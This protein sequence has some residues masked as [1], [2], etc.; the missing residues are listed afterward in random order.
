[1]FSSYDDLEELHDS[2]NDFPD[3]ECLN[4]KPNKTNNSHAT[5]KPAPKPKPKAKRKPGRPKKQQPPPQSTPV[6][7]N[8]PPSPKFEDEDQE[9]QGILARSLGTNQLL[10]TLGFRASS[11]KT[12]DS[13]GGDQRA[14][15]LG[16]SADSD[17][18]GDELL[19]AIDY[20][21]SLWDKYPHLK[22]VPSITRKKFTPESNIEDVE[23]EIEKLEDLGQK[24]L[25]DKMYTQIWYL[26]TMF[27]G[28]I[29]AVSPAG[30]LL[31]PD[32]TPA[33][34]D[35]LRLSEKLREE[36]VVKQAR[37]VVKDLFEMFPV[38]EYLADLGDPRVQLAY[39]V[40]TC[41]MGVYQVNSSRIPQ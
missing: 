27:I 29:A 19:D 21:E 16:E 34:P 8:P 13:D 24:P 28:K 37:P 40:T 20:Y 3:M 17:P 35:P 4:L 25:R 39:T 1:M 32:A 10:D 2:D 14:P 11:P 30:D 18:D 12:K 41:A 15:G 23:T 38:L 7:P 6:V 33:N 22:L 31:E 5:A 26:M 36:D 9:N